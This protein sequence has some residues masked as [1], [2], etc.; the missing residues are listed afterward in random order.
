MKKDSYMLLT[1]EGSFRHILRWKHLLVKKCAFT[2][3][4][5]KEALL[6]GYE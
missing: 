4:D 3:S 5:N 6:V 1:C 2:H